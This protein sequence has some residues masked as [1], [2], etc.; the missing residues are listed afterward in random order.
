MTVNE[1]IKILEEIEDKEKR[2]KGVAPT[3]IITAIYF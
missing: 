3:I 1:L 2:S